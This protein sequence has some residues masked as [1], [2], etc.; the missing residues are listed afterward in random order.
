LSE[1]CAEVSEEGLLVLLDVI[2]GLTQALLFHKSM[3]R[4]T[5]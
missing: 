5:Y 1:K 3:A 2:E 4:L